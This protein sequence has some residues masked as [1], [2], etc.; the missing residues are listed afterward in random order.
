MFFFP[1]SKLF[2]YTENQSAGFADGTASA[3]G[4][5]VSPAT[6]GIYDSGANCSGTYVSGATSITVT[7]SD[8]FKKND[9]IK[10]QDEIFLITAITS[11]TVIAVNT[12]Q[13]G[14][15]E[16]GHF[17]GA[18]INH[19]FLN[20]V[21]DS[22][23]K[24]NGKGFYS[25]NNFFGYGRNNIMPMGL[26]PGSITLQFPDPS[27]QEFGMSDQS[28]N[29]DSG[30]TVSTIYS[31][32]ITPDNAGS[33]TQIDFVVD[34][35]NTNWGGSNGV[36]EKINAV[37]LTKWKDGT[38]TYLPTISIIN[39]DLRITSGSRIFGT[40]STAGISKIVLAAPSSGTTMFGVNRIPAIGSIKTTV[41]VIYPTDDRS[42]EFMYDDGF[43]ILS[44]PVGGGTIDYE[45]GAIQFTVNPNT[46]FQYAAFYNSA[47][48]GEATAVRDNYIRNI[49]AR[50]TSP[51]RDGYVRI[52]V[53]DMGTDDSTIRGAKVGSYR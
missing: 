53:E 52:E 24:T 1:N 48:S 11:T 35:T 18:D 40:A 47:L 25:A 20:E 6:T 27:Y 33:A 13:L 30:L 16:A 2:D 12:A 28:S 41:S 49:E 44:S 4:A 50:S 26:V 38:F 43:G 36:V 46:T 10:I 8:Y 37:F 7:D 31:F 21:G 9:Y 5:F 34:S 19:Y 22:F 51:F 23:L 29:T 17:D 15:S 39:G 42:G 45:T 3:S 14:T 32:N